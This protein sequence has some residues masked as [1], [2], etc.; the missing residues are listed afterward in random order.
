[1]RARCAFQ[2][3][4]APHAARM[5]HEPA[6]RQASKDAAG[7]DMQELL[8]KLREVEH[9][10]AAIKH[11]ATQL[12]PQEPAGACCHAIWRLAAACMPCSSRVKHEC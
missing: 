2:H 10:L 1:L 8:Q 4:R 6:C 12:T 5:L 3:P 11:A 9:H 7:A